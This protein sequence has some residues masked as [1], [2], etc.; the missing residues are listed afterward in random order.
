MGRYK[1]CEKNLTQRLQK[2]Q[3]LHKRPT[4]KLWKIY[5]SL[6]T[7][8]QEAKKAYG[9]FL[10]ENNIMPSQLT[11]LNTEEMRQHICVSI[12]TT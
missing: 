3:K 12:Y 5:V 11:P 2:E 7:C 10:T 8:L 9:Q 6:D 1:N 4:K